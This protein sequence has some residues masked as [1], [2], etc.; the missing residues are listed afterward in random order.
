MARQT[1]LMRKEKNRLAQQKHRRKK[2]EEQRSIKKKIEQL[3][4]T[5]SSISDAV[6]RNDM[7]A[8]YSI[9]YNIPMAQR[10]PAMLMSGL[11]QN[12]PFINSTAD[13]PT[14]AL[15]T[16]SDNTELGVFDFDLNLDE[17][18]QRIYDEIST[19]ILD[20]DIDLGTKEDHGIMDLIGPHAM[21]SPISI[22]P[23]ALD[24]MAPTL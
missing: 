17:D 10:T 23:T 8:L 22:N 15:S 19:N 7:S 13:V 2:L 3:E 21:L 24:W 5:L 11:L 1:E 6:F 9:L 20:T 14:M 12:D 18:T 4:S 16:L